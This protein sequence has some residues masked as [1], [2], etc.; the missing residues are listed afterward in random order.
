MEGFPDGFIKICNSLPG[1]HVI[2]HL[3][4]QFQRSIGVKCEP[5]VKCGSNAGKEGQ[6]ANIHL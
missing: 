5:A 4:R 1:I 2:D 6:T 3:E